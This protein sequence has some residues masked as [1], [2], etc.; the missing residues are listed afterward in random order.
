[1]LNRSSPAAKSR[2]AKQPRP[3]VPSAA[4]DTARSSS[5]RAP[6]ARSHSKTGDTRDDSRG[7]W[8]AASP[9]RPPPLFFVATASSPPAAPSPGLPASPLRPRFIAHCGTNCTAHFSRT[10]TH[11]LKTHQTAES[12][13]LDSS[14][15]LGRCGVWPSP[16]RPLAHPLAMVRRRCRRVLRRYMHSPQQIVEP[17]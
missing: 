1:M 2:P 6:A 16:L 5:P 8:L 12:V 10:Q 7:G 17:H 9:P 11:S 13:G 3:T 4:V 15:V 14:D